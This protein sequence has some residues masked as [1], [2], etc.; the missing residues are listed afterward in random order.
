MGL[1]KPN[2][3]GFFDMHGNI[4]CW[5]QDRLETPYT[6][7]AAAEDVEDIRD[8]LGIDSQKNR[9]LRGCTFDDPPSQLRS[10]FRGGNRPNINDSYFGF[11]P[12]QDFMTDHN[13]NP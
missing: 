9:V 8:L 7:F 3:L 4:W 13:E 12:A 1:K 6:H 5:C 2:D 10:A 11:R